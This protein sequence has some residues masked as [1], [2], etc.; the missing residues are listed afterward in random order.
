MY[1]NASLQE[2]NLNSIKLIFGIQSF[3]IELVVFAAKN[4]GILCVH[5]I[6]DVMGTL[7]SGEM[8]LIWPA[9]CLL[10]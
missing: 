9:T 8:K 3:C 1:D 10:C 5:T 6:L 7:L 4:R 2:R